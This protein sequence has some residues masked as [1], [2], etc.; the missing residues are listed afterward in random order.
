MSGSED[1]RLKPSELRTAHNRIVEA[2]YGSNVKR[3]HAWSIVGEQNNGHHT[4]NMLVMLLALHPNPNLKLIRAITFHDSAEFLIGDTPSPALRRFPELDKA[5]N[6][7]QNHVLKHHFGI[8]LQELSL[9]ERN[10][11]HAL[12]K[13]EAYVFG[14]RQ[15]SLG[16][17]EGQAIVKNVQDWF[18]QRIRDN[19]M[20]VQLQQYFEFA[21]DV[22]KGE[23]R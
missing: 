9:T 16:N 22:D 2:R 7:A 3:Y 12:D 4:F 10:W 19:M 13:L 20:P 23:Y 14:L 11:L 5:Y 18:V 8:D 1:V 15:I 6:N 17:S 21:E